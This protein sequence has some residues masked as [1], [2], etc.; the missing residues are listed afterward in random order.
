MR[1]W[2]VIAADIGG[3]GMLALTRAVRRGMDVC[4]AQRIEVEVDSYF[5]QAHRWVQMLG[6]FEWEGRMRKYTPDGR[7]CD[8]YAR[9]R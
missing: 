6:G 2:A 8:R 3:S 5:P 1:A 9:V 7:D 4:T